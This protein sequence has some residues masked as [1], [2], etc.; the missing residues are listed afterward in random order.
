MD[1]KLRWSISIAAALALTAMMMA[2]E[3][4]APGVAGASGRGGFGGSG[5]GGGRGGFTGTGFVPNPTYD[6]VPPELPA[7]LKPGGVLIF[8]KTNGFRDEASIRGSDAALAAICYERHWPLFVTETTRA[9]M[10]AAQLS[11][12]KVVV[13]NNNSGDLLTEEQ[14]AAFRGWLENGGSYVGVHG[15][16]GDPV[17][18]AGHTSLA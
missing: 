13:W 17:I 6:T 15:A 18:S 14:R 4:V 1:V 5:R 10:N 11:K 9:V 12:F 3:P 7:D 2:Q 8:A 16:G